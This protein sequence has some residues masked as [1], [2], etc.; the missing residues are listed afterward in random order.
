MAK[1][2][3]IDEAREK[4]TKKRK[5]GKKPGAKAKAA[6]TRPWDEDGTNRQPYQLLS[7]SNPQ[8]R[9]WKTAWVGPY[10][11]E[12]FVQK[13]Y[14]FANLKDYGD[15]KRTIPGEE[16]QHTGRIRRREMFLM[17]IPKDEY[18]KIEKAKVERREQQELGV[19]GEVDRLRGQGFH[20]PGTEK[21]S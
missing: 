13:G 14:R 9:G 21:V 1:V 8:R 6:A 10:F 7:L 11:I 2:G 17:E 16:G 19:Q 20:G 3:D 12:R 5:A 15:L 4:R 18:A